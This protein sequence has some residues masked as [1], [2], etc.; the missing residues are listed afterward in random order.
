ML[1]THTRV[2]VKFATFSSPFIGIYALSKPK[3]LLCAPPP[4]GESSHASDDQ[5]TSLPSYSFPPTHFF[6]SIIKDDSEQDSDT[7]SDQLDATNYVFW[8]QFHIFAAQLMEVVKMLTRWTLYSLPDTVR[9]HLSTNEQSAVPIGVGIVG[10]I[11]GMML[12]RQLNSAI[13][14]GTAV[15]FSGKLA[16]EFGFITVHWEKIDELKERFPIIGQAVS[17]VPAVVQSFLSLPMASFFTAGFLI[18]FRFL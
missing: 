16:I 15:F 3:I 11:V 1:R 18:G 8:N 10:G 13:M 9:E 2:L 6:R 4:L 14:V 5:S 7:E 17:M 12:K